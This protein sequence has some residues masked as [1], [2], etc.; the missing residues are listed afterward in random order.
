[1]NLK[2]SVERL[3]QAVN[4]GDDETCGCRMRVDVRKYPG[5]DSEGDAARDERPAQRCDFCGKPKLILKVVYTRHWRRE[6]EAA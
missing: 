6:D 4:G 2:T 5:E 3:E 1:M